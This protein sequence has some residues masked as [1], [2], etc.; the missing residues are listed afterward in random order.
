M[1]ITAQGEVGHTEA[2]LVDVLEEQIRC[3]Q[4]MLGALDLEDAA[5]K[6]GDPLRLNAAGADKAKL[7]E[8]LESLETERSGLAAALEVRLATV[9]RTPAGGKWRT[10]LGLLEQ[11]RARNQRNGALV[12]ARR[13]QVLAALRLLHGTGSDLYDSHGYE[14]MA[15]KAQ[16]LGSA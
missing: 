4:A 7:V 10:L 13:E 12:T 9:E 11:C 5:L 8:A 15:P 6:A 14:S 2:R 3:A 16:R 1:T